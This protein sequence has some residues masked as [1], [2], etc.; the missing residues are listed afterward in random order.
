MSALEFLQWALVC[1]LEYALFCPYLI[2]PVS[3]AAITF[4]TFLN[5]DLI[6][7]GLAGLTGHCMFDFNDVR[8][9]FGFSSGN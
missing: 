5:N 9:M 8:C 1:F 3:I 4:C 6:L 2:K 7:M